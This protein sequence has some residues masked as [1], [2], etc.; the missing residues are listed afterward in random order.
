MFKRRSKSRSQ[1]SRAGKRAKKNRTEEQRNLSRSIKP[2]NMA[3]LDQALQVAQLPRDLP[4]DNIQTI[5]VKDQKDKAGKLINT[6][7]ST[8]ILG[9]Q[10]TNL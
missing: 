10:P 8:S 7:E 2:N 4:S 9:T 6:A 3:D 1:A 5:N